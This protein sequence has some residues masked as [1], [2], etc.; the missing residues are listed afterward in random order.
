M[1]LGDSNK[2]MM[3][4]D[5]LAKLVFETDLGLLDIIWNDNCEETGKSFIGI[6]YV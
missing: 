6:L 1:D 5:D 4:M 3:T 2:K